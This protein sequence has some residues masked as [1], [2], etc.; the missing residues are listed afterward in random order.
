MG[1][2][3]RSRWL[4]DLGV[5]V[6]MSAAPLVALRPLQ[7]APFID[8]WAYAWSV[9]HLLQTGQLEILDWSVSLNVV[10]VLWGA[11]F[12]VPF[13]FSFTAL[14]LSTWVLS[15]LG[16][17]GLY[18][19]LRELGASRR[20][21]LLGVALVC[22]Y[23][24]YFILSFS[25][26]TDVPFVAMV[27]WFFAALVRSVER[28]SARALAAA[29]L[30]ACLA[31]AI[32]PVGVFLSGVLV[33]A[34]WLPSVR[35]GSLARRVVVAAAPVVVLL[36]L[37]LARP[38]LT[39]YRADL[40]GIEGSYAWRA[41]Y[42]T[43]DLVHLP[44]WL[45][46]H[47]TVVIGTL[48]TALVPLALGSLGRENV[49]A[50]LPG[51]LLLAAG[52]SAGLL[53][54]ERVAAPLDPEFTWSLRE[55]GGTETLV[56]ALAVPTR[57][58]GWALV[59]TLAAALLL[60]LALAPLFRRRPPREAGSLAWGAL[61]YF[62][63]TAVL[64]MFYDRYLLPLVVIVAT[65]HLATVGIARPQLALA[66]VALLATISGVGTWDHLQYSH[67]LWEAV[68]WA[69]RAGIEDRALDGGYVVNGWL[70]YAH[71]EHAPRAPDGDV[72][73]PWVNGGE[74]PRYRIGNDV[75]PGTRVL[76]VV[77]YRRVLAPSGSIYVVDR[78]PE[79]S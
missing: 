69:R 37:T 29:V 33:L 66:G 51:A 34:P 52:L 57:S 75:P 2:C 59:L 65:L 36:L 39:A 48:G 54:R 62:V 70:Q 5:V 42:W 23:P 49:R 55:L 30:F 19:L 68:G 28:D 16:L 60:A 67:A 8:D 22:F 74:P 1:S 4:S 50:A 13:G 76:H 6:L 78:T 61:G 3:S 24:V 11:L 40:T 14:R 7:N 79:T 31:T 17:L 72:R 27:I 18:A 25:F 77:R 71:P 9:E 58:L 47:L 15:L 41:A 10:H 45:A 38:A 12:C 43:L 73:V 44:A 53:L 21:T 46:M 56:P 63:L 20:D 26:M 35:W 32:R 64:W